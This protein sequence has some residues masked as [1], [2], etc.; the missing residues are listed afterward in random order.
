MTNVCCDFYLKFVLGCGKLL[1]YTFLLFLFSLLESF[2][3]LGQLDDLDEVDES[4]K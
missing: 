4:V 1:F 3:I 2:K